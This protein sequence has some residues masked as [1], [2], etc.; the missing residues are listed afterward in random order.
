[1]RPSPGAAGRLFIAANAKPLRA[2][3]QG[4]TRPQHD[5]SELRTAQRDGEREVLKVGEWSRD[6]T[7]DKGVEDDGEVLRR[8]APELPPTRHLPQQIR[9]TPPVGATHAHARACTHACERANTHTHLA[10]EFG[11][12]HGAAMRWRRASLWM[13]VHGRRPAE[14]AA[15]PAREADRPRPSDGLRR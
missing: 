2:R 4:L 3:S 15:G 13:R 8:L 14:H 1:M 11:A 9:T 12:Q 5:C 6:L 10:A 7:E